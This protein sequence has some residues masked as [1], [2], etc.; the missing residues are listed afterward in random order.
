M[1]PLIGIV[2]L[3]LALDP[4]G[5]SGER[6]TPIEGVF[7]RD[8]ELW[9]FKADTNQDYFEKQLTSDGRQ[10]SGP[11][12]NPVGSRLGLI[13]EPYASERDKALAYVGLWNHQDTNLSVVPL[14]DVKP[15]EVRYVTGVTEF[16]WV[17]SNVLAVVG[18]IHPDASELQLVDTDS[19]RATY[20]AIGAKFKVSPD[21]KHVVHCGEIPH[22]VP[23]EKK[24]DS[25]VFDGKTV[26]GANLETTAYAI[27]GDLTTDNGFTRVAFAVSPRENPARV[28][29]VVA[30]KEGVFNRRALP[31]VS[32]N[33]S[34]EMW[35]TENPSK[36]VAIVNATNSGL[37]GT[38]G[39][40][41]APP[42][43]RQKQTRVKEASMSKLSQE[44]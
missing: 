44:W 10:K 21:A 1:K 33:S 19:K 29:I 23:A 13:L 35:F 20:S 37:L 42:M 11:K 28:E 22:F 12:W 15:G 36:S 17:N 43:V 34:I 7:V 16:W 25:V 18:H 3:F 39:L 4:A 27:L 38:E 26:F 40:S 9:W 5:V 31:R 14:F 30:T 41:A 24:R 32:V 6:D 8:S 2:V